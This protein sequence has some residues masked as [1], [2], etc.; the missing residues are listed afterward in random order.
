MFNILEKK[1]RGLLLQIE[2]GKTT[3]QE[4]GIG[5]W[6]NQLKEIDEP[7]YDI[8]VERYLKAVGNAK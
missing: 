1:I 4:S 6:L 5:K 3:L 8:L 2:S 7:C